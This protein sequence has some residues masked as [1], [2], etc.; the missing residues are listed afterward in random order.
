VTNFHLT[1]DDVAITH[2]NF[3]REFIK[4]IESKQVASQD[5]QEAERKQY[6]VQRAEQ[7]RIASVTRTGG[8]AEASTIITSAMERTGNTIVE[9]RRMDAAKESG[10]EHL[11]RRQDCDGHAGGAK[12][13]IACGLKGS[14]DFCSTL[15]DSYTKVLV[16]QPMKQ[17]QEN[18]PSGE[19]DMVLAKASTWVLQISSRYHAT[20]R[21][22]RRA[23]RNAKG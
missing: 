13:E 21:A 16:R 18:W 22:D 10:R 9:V 20:S 2:L 8:D 12:T 17:L 11:R 6:L 5:C 15:P 19:L 7:E 3:G 14:Y 23:A 4:A 1:L